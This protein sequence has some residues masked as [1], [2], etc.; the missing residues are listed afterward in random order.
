MEG[1][2]GLVFVI[3]AGYI[4]FS[5][6]LR[7][8]KNENSPVMVA[9]ARLLDKKADVHMSTDANGAMST[10]ETLYLIFELDTGNNIKLIVNGRIYRNAPKNEWGILTFQG[11]RFIKFESSSGIIER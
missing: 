5:W 11:T 4:V 3:A 6:I 2:F 9:K 10:S 7:Y 1:I 8:I